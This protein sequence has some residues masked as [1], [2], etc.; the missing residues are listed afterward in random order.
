MCLKVKLLLL[1]LCVNIYA[2]GL[3]EKLA[4]LEESEEKQE[5]VNNALWLKLRQHDYSFVAMGL[6]ICVVFGVALTLC[7]C[8]DKSKECKACCNIDYVSDDTTK[9]VSFDHNLKVRF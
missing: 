9:G 6:G 3:Q 4:D 1:C 8:G 7:A 2:T 5:L